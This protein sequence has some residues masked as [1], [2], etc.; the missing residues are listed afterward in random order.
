[1][2][3]ERGPDFFDPGL[4]GHVAAA[5]RRGDLELRDVR[6]ARKRH[7]EEGASRADPTTAG[8]P[9]QR[10]DMAPE[11]G[12]T[13]P[14][15]GYGD[16]RDAFRG[17]LV[18][19]GPFGV[20]CGSSLF[21]FHAAEEQE[22]GTAYRLGHVLAPNSGSLWNLGPARLESVVGF[23]LLLK[24]AGSE[25]LGFADSFHHAVA[26]SVDVVSGRSPL[27][28]G[29][30]SQNGCERHNDNPCSHGPSPRNGAVG[31]CGAGAGMSGVAILVISVWPAPARSGIM[32]QG[33]CNCNSKSIWGVAHA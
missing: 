4:C 12:S 5:T 21:L 33:F 1:M 9:D 32:A 24:T 22:I 27:G 13:G 7:D 11:A 18:S 31:V 29:W 30:R 23:L 15:R 14:A 2:V 19:E 16:P 20:L 25:E 8:A 26:G 6:G 28:D 10:P 3:V 17:R